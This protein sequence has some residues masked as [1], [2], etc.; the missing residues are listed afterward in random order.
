MYTVRNAL[1]HKSHQP[2]RTSKSDLEA[3]KALDEFSIGEETDQRAEK[4]E[5]G[6]P[7]GEPVVASRGVAADGLPA[8]AAAEDGLQG[9]NNLEGGHES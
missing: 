5:D 4:A 3:V 2:K 9:A 1:H 8:V 6:E 7:D